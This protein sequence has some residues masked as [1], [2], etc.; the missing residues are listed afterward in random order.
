MI[1]FNQ[2][3]T[4]LNN[5]DAGHQK[6]HRLYYYQGN[7]YYPLFGMD[8]KTKKRVNNMIKLFWK[9]HRNAIIAHRKRNDYKSKVEIYDKQFA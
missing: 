5:I 4:I 9:K 7:F 3:V 2:D 8:E 1:D 6:N